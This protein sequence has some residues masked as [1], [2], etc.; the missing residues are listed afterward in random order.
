MKRNVLSI[1]E[2][3]FSYPEILVALC[4][5]AIGMAGL[6]SLDSFSARCNAVARQT[7][8]ATLIGQNILEE[9]R[10]EGYDALTDAGPVDGTLGPLDANGQLSASGKYN[11]QWDVQQDTPVSGTKLVAVE[12]SWQS[13]AV[14][15]KRVTLQT[16]FRNGQ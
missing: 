2:F 6:L 8:A 14:S 4:T 3:G 10:L 7:R 11:V 9:L 5:F 12:V 13:A 15:N 1:G 16:V